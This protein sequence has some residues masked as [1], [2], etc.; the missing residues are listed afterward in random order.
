MIRSDLSP[1]ARALLR[2][3]RSFDDPSDADSRR[4]RAS[5]LSRVGA[6]AGMGVAIGATMSSF[7]FAGV[8]AL[9][10]GTASKI[11]AA[12]LVVAG[13]SAGAHVATRSRVP[14]PAPIVVQASN[15]SSHQSLEAATLV[16]SA[17]AVAS[18]SETGSKARG[19]GRA[20]RPRRA[21][22]DLDGEVRL[23]EGADAEL[24][25]G[26]AEAALAQLAEHAAKYP[27]GALA[28][29]R[30]GIRAI[31]LCR[32]GRSSEGKPLAERFLS[33]TRKSSLATRVRTACAI[34]KTAD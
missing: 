13:L 4:V 11:G 6:V 12:L 10:G 33:A 22:P 16:D 25:R 18:P 21:T 7:S 28:D 8:D 31:A 17:R 9:L 29:E 19:V 5:V 27:Q 34:E 15:P 30:E 2:A 24:R 20:L 26:D 1:Q 23:L 32:A 14:A 3:A